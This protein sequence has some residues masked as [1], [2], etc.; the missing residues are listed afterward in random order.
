M[1]IETARQQYITMKTVGTPASE[2]ALRL[3]VAE[4]MRQHRAG[5]APLP[6][7]PPEID[8][9]AA[10]PLLLGRIRMQATRAA[11]QTEYYAEV[12]SRIGLDPERLTWE[13]LARIP[14]TPK[15]DMRDRAASF[16]A[17][18]TMPQYRSFTGGTTGGRPS[19][20]WWSERELV[21]MT[22]SHTINAMAVPS[23]EFQFDLVLDI[24]DST[25]F[26]SMMVG[27]RIDSIWGDATM[28]GRMHD[29]DATVDQLMETHRFG[30]QTSQPTATVAFASYWGAVVEA[31]RRRGR[32][33]GD[34]SLRMINACGEITTSG[35]IRR[36]QDVFG[37]A[38]GM[39]HA[40]GSYGATEIYGSGGGYPCPSGHMHFGNGLYAELLDPDTYAPAAPGGVATLVATVLPPFRETTLLLRYDM[41]DLFQTLDAEP[42]CGTPGTAVGMILGKRSL[43][44]RHPDGRWTCPRH[45]LEAL[46]ALDEVP[47]PARCGF[48]ASGDGV[49]VEVVVP[50][51]AAD[52]RRKVGDSLEQ[53]G[54]PLRELHIRDRRDDL[55]RPYPLRCDGR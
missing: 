22:L 31:A 33:P 12:F 51:A 1:D 55:A 20:I 23:V 43:S 37:N 30:G 25:Q 18:D 14:I 27:A 19:G 49:A 45:V 6:L 17:T 26:L 50:G 29:P 28:W 41:E 38:P 9:D 3:L 40:W 8:D 21:L 5:E 36:S 7:E 35:L 32:R 16:V 53:W 4:L 34:F 2:E 52:V 24:G 13:D 15:A 48:W 10:R 54:V 47:L 39:Y 42:A 11:R 46:E 44:V